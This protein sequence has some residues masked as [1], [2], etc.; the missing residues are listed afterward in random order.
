MEI[1]FAAP[2]QAA[3]S[4]GFVPMSERAGVKATKDGDKPD[5]DAHIP[6]HYRKAFGNR[7]IPRHRPR[8]VNAN[9]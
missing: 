8:E 9:E 3:S 5:P 4:M 1:S 2:E 6:E 7:P